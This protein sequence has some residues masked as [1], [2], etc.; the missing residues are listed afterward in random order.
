MLT[1]KEQVYYLSSGTI[2]WM[3][4]DLQLKD[5]SKYTTIDKLREEFN[6]YCELK[7]WNFRTWQDAYIQFKNDYNNYNDI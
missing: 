2:N 6:I 7:N 4:R 5:A 1:I 3:A